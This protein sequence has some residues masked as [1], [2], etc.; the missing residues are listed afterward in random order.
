MLL[1]RLGQ[2]K[3]VEIIFCEWVVG[4]KKAELQGQVKA[5]GRFSGAGYA[6]HDDIG[7]VIMA[8]ACAIIVIQRK[9]DGVD[10][11]PVGLGVANGV[12]L[13]DLVAGAH[14]QFCFQRVQE[15]AEQ[16]QHHAFAA[17]QNLA[18]FTVDQC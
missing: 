4:G 13:V 5:G 17:V 6:D 8:G 18:V 12:T 14:A 3:I 16:V 15:G 10:A 7:L 11:N 2:A 9:V 1:Q